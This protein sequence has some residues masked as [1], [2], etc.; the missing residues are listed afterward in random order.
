VGN[1]LRGDDAFGPELAARLRGMAGL[2]CID[3]GTTPENQTGA[4]VRLGPE[5]VLIAD[6]VHLGLE[7]GAMAVLGREEI[8][9]Y[10][11]LSTHDMSPALFMERLEEAAGCEV[12]MIA[13]Q[14]E[15]LE[16]GTGMSGPV[17]DSL[18]ALAECAADLLRPGE[19]SP[20]R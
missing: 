16:F 1:I 7:P 17:A 13:V 10:A 3:A 6:A 12:M 11:G 18:E 5:A 20:S 15:S 19:P 14:P 2:S 8:I 4:V 9:R